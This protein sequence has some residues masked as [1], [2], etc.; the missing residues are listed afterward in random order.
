ML[1]ISKAG[2]QGGGCGDGTDGGAWRTLAGKKES[3]DIVNGQL[4]CD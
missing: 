4:K 3:N 2:F 1:M